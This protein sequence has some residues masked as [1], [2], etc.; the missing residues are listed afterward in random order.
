MSSIRR[1]LLTVLLTIMTLGWLVMAATGYLA[2]K[3]E[4]EELFD[5]QL[6]QSARVLHALVD[7][8]MDEKN[9]YSQPGGSIRLD[10]EQPGHLY[11][12]RVAFRVLDRSNAV[13]LQSDSFPKIRTLP[14]IPGYS[15]ITENGNRWRYFVIHDLNHSVTL[16][17]AQH[18]QPRDELIA[19]IARQSLLPFIFM[20]PVMTILIW[21]GIGRGLRPLKTTASDISSRTPANLKA[22]DHGNVPQEVLPL[23]NALNQLFERLGYAMESERRFT[24]DAAHELRTPLAAI[25]IQAQVALRSTD[26]DE[27]QQ[28]LEHIVSGMD[29]SSHLVRQL[30]V[31]ARVDPDASVQEYEKLDLALL[32]R[33]VS[34]DIKAAADNKQISLHI[35]ADTQGA[36]ILGQH[37]LLDV[38]IRNL[39]DNAIRYTPPRGDVN[40]RVDVTATHACLTISDNGPGVSDNSLKRIFDRFHRGIG[41]RENGSG[42][43]LSIVKRIAELHD[44]G[45]E[46]RTRTKADP[47]FTIAV[48]FHLQPSLSKS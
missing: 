47:G 7:Q 45:I 44:A 30:L 22:I 16:E 27:R 17:V 31:L 24:M 46:T 33:E 42:L 8:Q 48:S 4:V 11:E 29:R 3:R 6:A 26:D 19:D 23:I 15:D 41:T 39:L 28:A 32:L 9:N 12:S 25:K 35:T 5:A 1:R 10:Y 21:V 40:C 43:G 2:A 36:L 20:L 13:L 38:L 18:Y 37:Q 34:E 14:T